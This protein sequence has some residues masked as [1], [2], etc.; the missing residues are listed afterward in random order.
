M[1]AISQLSQQQQ[2]QCFNLKGN[3]SLKQ[4]N[5]SSFNFILGVIGLYSLNDKESFNIDYSAALRQ[6]D[7][8]QFY[9]MFN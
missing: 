6:F 4:W 8:I 2:C 5:Y 7:D 9:E 1:E 3:P